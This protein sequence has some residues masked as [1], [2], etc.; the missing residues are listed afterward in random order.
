[1]VSDYYASAEPGSSRPPAHQAFAVTS[2]GR[3][4]VFFDGIAP[5][6][7]DMAPG[8]TATPLEQVPAL[9]IP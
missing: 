8:G 7:R 6:E 9:K 3:V 4:F 5:R 1:V 2:A